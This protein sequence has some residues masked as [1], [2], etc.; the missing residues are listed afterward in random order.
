MRV[1][2]GSVQFE[3]IDN[4]AKRLDTDEARLGWAHHGIVVTDSGNVIACHQG[5]PTV[6]LFD[7]EGTLKRS[8]DLDLIEAHQM[9]LVKEG[10]TEYLWV[11]DNGSK[12]R[13][14]EGYRRAGVPVPNEVSGQVVK[15][16]LDGEIVMR[17]ERPPLPIYLD[18][19]YSPTSMAVNE[20]RHGGNGDIWVSDG[21]GK[22]H[23]HRYDKMGN[24]LA[25]INGEEGAGGV[26][27]PP[28]D[29]CRLEEG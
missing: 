20:E 29:L 21:Y 2:S 24:Y 11:A 16:T 14:E 6:M 18:G 22:F 5:K 26:L 4:W 25:S 1:G 27:H 13:R 10:A 15:T 12:N 23:V 9:A 7:A 3:W 17:L 28:R 8:W 19:G